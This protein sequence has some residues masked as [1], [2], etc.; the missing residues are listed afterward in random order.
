[1]GYVATDQDP[2]RAIADP[3]RRLMLDALREGEQTV[4]QLTDLV[5]LRQSTVSQ[6]LQVLRLAGLVSERRE[7]RNSFYAARPGGLVAVAD[8]LEK[9]R[10]FWTDRL[11][12]LEAHLQKK[13]Q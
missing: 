12:A 4:S 3:N 9:Y 7:G 6:H 5:K 10:A 1:M 11:D 13:K 8:W 2:F